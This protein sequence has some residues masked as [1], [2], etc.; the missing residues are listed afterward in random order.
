MSLA[1]ALAEH[2]GD[3]N[4]AV[5]ALGAV[6]M[7]VRLSM[8]PDEYRQVQEA[9]PEAEAWIKRAMSGSMARTGEILALQ[10]PETVRRRLD[11]I[12][13]NDREIERLAEDVHGVL[14]QILGTETFEHLV[15]RVP[16]LSTAKR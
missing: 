8:K 15:T 12:G 14:E 2:F 5:H 1:D 6:F 16:L 10:S 11:Q 13:L 9:L 3:E 4:K 7:V